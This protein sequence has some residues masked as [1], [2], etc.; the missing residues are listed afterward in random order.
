MLEAAHLG[1]ALQ[2]RDHADQH[3]QARARGRLHRHPDEEDRRRRRARL[4]AVR[5]ADRRPSVPR[6]RLRLDPRRTARSRAPARETIVNWTKNLVPPDFPAAAGR[7]HHRRHRQGRG[8]SED[9]RRRAAGLPAARSRSAHLR[10]HPVPA[11]P[12][13]LHVRRVR[14]LP[15][16]PHRA[17][18]ALRPAARRVRQPLDP[19]PRARTRATAKPAPSTTRTSCG[20]CGRSP[21]AWSKRTAR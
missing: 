10:G 11:R 8:A 1:D 7:D 18:G 12:P 2:D 6:R 4:H 5:R 14:A 20:R 16:E 3:D 13:Q 21:R 19:D 9:H 17:D 15:R